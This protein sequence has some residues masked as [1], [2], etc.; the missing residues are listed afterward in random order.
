VAKVLGAAV[1]RAKRKCWVLP[2][3]MTVRVNEHT[4]YEPD[5]LIYGGDKL[6]P[7]A[8]EVP[9]PVVL[10]EVLS[11]ST[12]HI[13]ASAKFAGYFKLPSVQHFLIVDPDQYTVIHHARS[14]REVIQTR[15]VGRAPITLDPPGIKVATAKFFPAGGSRR[16]G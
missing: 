5:A 9:N 6:P 12:R 4:A 1:D 7:H 11:P 14:A 2:D 16:R 10:V 13:D 8:V 15:V 3:G